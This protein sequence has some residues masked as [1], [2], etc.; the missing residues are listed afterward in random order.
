MHDAQ[1]APYVPAGGAGLNTTPV[2]NVKS[3]F[4][5][6]SLVIHVFLL[7]LLLNDHC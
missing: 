6:Q 1:P 7:L 4:D 3:D 2:Y 5:Y